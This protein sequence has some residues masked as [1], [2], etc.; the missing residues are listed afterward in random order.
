MICSICK[1]SFHLKSFE[2]AKVFCKH[3]SKC[4]LRASNELQERFYCNICE[5][6]FQLKKSFTEHVHKNHVNGLNCNED[7]VLRIHSKSNIESSTG[8]CFFK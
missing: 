7:E 4:P 5:T 1:K 8:K 3:V 6:S 2:A